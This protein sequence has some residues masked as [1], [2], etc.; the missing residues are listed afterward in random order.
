[1]LT[2]NVPQ[3]GFLGMVVDVS[4]AARGDFELAPGFA[5]LVNYFV[6][7]CVILF[8]WKLVAYKGELVGKIYLI[9]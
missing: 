3:K 2:T 1:M 5:Y 8:L 9:Q 7:I 4:K 6:S